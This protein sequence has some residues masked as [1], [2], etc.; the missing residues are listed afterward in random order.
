MI[1]FAD[2]QGALISGWS[3]DEPEGVWS[4]GKTAYLGFIVGSMLP[5]AE[6]ILRIFRQMESTACNP[7]FTLLTLCC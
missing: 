4:I 1:S 6:G 3:G 7:G 5:R 2:G